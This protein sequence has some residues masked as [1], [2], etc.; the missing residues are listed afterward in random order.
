MSAIAYVLAFV[1]VLAAATTAVSQENLDRDK[2][3]PKLFAASCVACH[4]S[5]RGLAKGR[6]SFAL[7]YYLR[8]H[9]TSSAATAQ[10]LTAYLQSMDTPPAK[11]KAK[12]KAK[13]GTAKSPATERTTTGTVTRPSRPRPPAAIPAR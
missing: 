2:S 7:S 11:A 6:I 13:A 8:Q 3:G 4:K 1:I 5:P 12:A 10:I 9:Y